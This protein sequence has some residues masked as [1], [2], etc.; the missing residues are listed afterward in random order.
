MEHLRRETRDK[1]CGL[2]SRAKRLKT[3][4]QLKVAGL[5]LHPHVDLPLTMEE[6][7]AH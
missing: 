3:V 4:L 5:G 7:L 2:V 6:E 1:G